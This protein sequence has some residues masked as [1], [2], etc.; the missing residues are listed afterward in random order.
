VAHHFH[1]SEIAGV[2]CAS[3]LALSAPEGGNPRL[4]VLRGSAI[5]VRNQRRNGRGMEHRSIGAGGRLTAA[6]ERTVSRADFIAARIA[7]DRGNV[8]PSV[9]HFGISYSHACR[10]RAGWREDGRRAAP[11]PYSARGWQDGRRNGWSG[12]EASRG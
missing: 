6:A 5:H 4:T 9:V 10:I 12:L 3:D 11:V 7:A 8:W 1:E 2:P